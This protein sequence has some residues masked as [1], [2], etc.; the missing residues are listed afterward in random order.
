MP[1][2]PCGL[3][4][5]TWKHSARP[6]RAVPPAKTWVNE[7]CVGSP[8]TVMRAGAADRPRP[9]QKF[10]MTYQ[11]WL[12]TQPWAM[13]PQEFHDTVQLPEL[14]AVARTSVGA[15]GPS[16]PVVTSIGADEVCWEL[17]YAVT[18]SWYSVSGNRC[19]SGHRGVALDA[20]LAL[21]AGTARRT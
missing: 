3:T 1:I 12:G 6:S 11:V 18:V 10:G 2:V 17:M 21:A 15:A 14:S 4:P 13:P 9:S 19:V 7:C 8:G 16:G 20:Y 5:W